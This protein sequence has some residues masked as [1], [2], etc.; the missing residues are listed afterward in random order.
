M[1]SSSGKEQCGIRLY[2]DTQCAYLKKVRVQTVRISVE[3]KQMPAA[4]YIAGIKSEVLRERPDL[5]HIQHEFSFFRGILGTDFIGLLLVLR[6]L[7]IPVVVTMHAVLRFT[8][9]S[10]RSPDISQLAI[11]LLGYILWCFAYFA[12]FLSV[13]LLSD[14]VIVHTNRC[15]SLLPIKQKVSVIPHATEISDHTDSQDLRPGE[16]LNVIT[17]GFFHW[18]KG[19]DL[20]YRAVASMPDVD[21]VVAG[22]VS[23]DARKSVFHGGYFDRL[24]SDR[25]D[26]VSIVICCPVPSRLIACSDVVLLSYRRSEIEHASGVF[27]TALSLGKP[28]VATRVTEMAEYEG[29]CLTV[30]PGSPRAIL[31]ALQKM[32]SSELRRHYA[33]KSRELA[34][35]TAFPLIADQHI[36]LYQR[37]IGR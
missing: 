22:S 16:K 18:L 19:I 24:R 6:R 3:Q 13:P 34:G 11:D 5:V 2:S 23:L 27:H 36:R 1:L 8:K 7:H 15:R 4:Q 28:I 35:K 26:N 32:R 30:E 20:A 33:E 25:P 37:T 12:V 9:P 31:E 29:Y 17:F 21:Y 14:G 10:I